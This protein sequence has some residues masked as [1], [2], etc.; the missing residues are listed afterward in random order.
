MRPMIGMVLAFGLVAFT[1]NDAAA[2]GISLEG[3]AADGRAVVSIDDPFD[4]MG[5]GQDQFRAVC[6]GVPIDRAALNA[7]CAMCSH[8]Y[9]KVDKKAGR[10]SARSPNRKVKVTSKRTCKRGEDGKVCTHRVT[11]GK[12]GAFVYSAGPAYMKAKMHVYFRADSN[13][14]V[15]LFKANNPES[16]GG[17]DAIYTIDL[18]PEPPP[19]YD[20][21]VWGDEGWTDDDPDEW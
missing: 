15:V 1:A 7:G 10:A 19:D 11:V 16:G 12:V 9:C 5:T 17:E 8:D 14:V 4:M 13:A 3:W 2:Q 21:P 18:D 20:E 6:V